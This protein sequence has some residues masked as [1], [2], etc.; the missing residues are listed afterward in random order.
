MSFIQLQKNQTV[1]FS[2]AQIQKRLKE[3]A[4]DINNKYKNS[5]PLI[6]PLLKGAVIFASDLVRILSH[7]GQK[8]TIEYIGIK[9]YKGTESS[10]KP[11]FTLDIKPEII[12]NK[13][14]II[15]EDIV[16]TGH[17]L[18]FL[19]DHFK[20]CNPTSIEVAALISK[21][22]KREIEVPI[23]YLGFEIENIWIEGYGLDTNEYNRELP[24]IVARHNS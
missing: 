6:I 1:L 19:L 8:M 21:P 9:S 4:I 13:Q 2:E 11:Y 3:M 17:T 24:F 10:K 16:D 20:K 7:L 22:K 5:V 15:L 23:H 18:H 12:Q 14:I